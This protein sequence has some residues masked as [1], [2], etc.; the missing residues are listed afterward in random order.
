MAS[1]LLTPLPFGSTDSSVILNCSLTSL[2][3]AQA[4]LGA[5]TTAGL[6]TFD[7]VR[8]VKPNASGGGLKFTSV[9]GYANLD[10][11]G[12]ISMDIQRDAL[13]IN[14]LVAPSVGKDWGSNTPFIVLRNAAGGATPADYLRYYHDAN[15]RPQMGG[16]AG[17]AAGTLTSPGTAVSLEYT[18]AGKDEYVRVSLNWWGNEY[19]IL[20]DGAW[21]GGGIRPGRLT[22]NIAERI[23]V[24]S[25]ANMTFAPAIGYFARNLT[26]STRPITRAV[27][28]RF[29]KPGIFS[30]SFGTRW[31]ATNPAN[32]TTDQHRDVIG[33]EIF[34]AALA[35]YGLGVGGPHDY[36]YPVYD[37]P[38]GYVRNG[39]ATN[40]NSK[41]AQAV[42]AGC[43][44][45]H[46][47][48]W[49][50]DCIDVNFATNLAQTITDFKG[51]IVAL[52]GA[53]NCQRVF[54]HNVI[55]TSGNW[56]SSPAG[57]AFAEA[58]VE[59]ANRIID[60][61]PAYIN[62]NFPQYAGRCFVVDDFKEFGGWNPN[63]TFVQG[64]Y[65][66]TRDDGHPI[67]WGIIAMARLAARAEVN[68]LT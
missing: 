18:S 6:N 43:T 20:V 12:H 29:A 54:I 30:H 68:A 34:R 33:Y 62:A 2:A 19:E 63:P 44:S 56:T 14:N 39:A 40:M 47:Y 10:V 50:N 49:T 55:S 15:E 48:G 46:Y 61:M 28:P 42:A 36:T 58:N 9:P 26:V 41:L 67:G 3:E 31:K 13:C 1:T 59:T 57:L 65:R 5:E 45:Y 4:L 17:G 66:G 64:F 38:G 21:K 27:D 22:G 32:L 8:G 11:A 60:T 52:L 23:D 51:H 24:M 37:V 53:N 35:E 7:S 16:F 25:G